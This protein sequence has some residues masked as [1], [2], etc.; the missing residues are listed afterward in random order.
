MIAL[1]CREHRLIVVLMIAWGWAADAALAQ[2]VDQR[3][4]TTS[5]FAGVKAFVAPGD[6]V[7]VTDTAGTTI[8]GKLAELTDDAVGVKIKG[9]VRSVRGSRSPAHSTAAAGLSVH[10]RTDR[11]RGRRHP[12]HLLARCGSKRMQWD[13]PR[14]LRGDLRG[15]CRRRG[16]R[17]LPDEE[18]DRVQGG[19]VEPSFQE[20]HDWSVRQAGSQRPA[21]RDEVL[22]REICRVARGRLMSS[23]GS[24]WAVSMSATTRSAS[25]CCAAHSTVPFRSTIPELP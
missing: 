6:V 5:S 20:R 22:K 16:D 4:T 23:E 24:R 2:T 17:P 9:R 13:V 10:G 11:R 8:K 25:S 1:V 12:W 19:D 14:G 7:Y 21:G 15:R 3:S 18:G